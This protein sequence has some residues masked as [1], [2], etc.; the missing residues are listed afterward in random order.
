M[1]LLA[2]LFDPLEPQLASAMLQVTGGSESRIRQ[3]VERLQEDYDIEFD[4]VLAEA[5]GR[6]IRGVEGLLF[7]GRREQRIDLCR[8][9][10]WKAEADDAIDPARV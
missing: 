3:I 9:E 2:Y 5:N 6:A 10:D 7:E 1:H 8:G 4:D